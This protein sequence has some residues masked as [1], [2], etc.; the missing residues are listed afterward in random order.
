MY[1]W[2]GVER[3]KMGN[4][5]VERDRLLTETHTKEKQVS[6]KNGVFVKIW[7]IPIIISFVG[8]IVSYVTMGES[9]SQKISQVE[10]Q[11]VED[12]VVNT[13]FYQQQGVIVGIVNAVD[14]LDKT[15]T[16]F[17]EKYDQN[18]EADSKVIR[19]ILKAVKA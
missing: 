17:I 1:E 9:F 15:Q 11:N 3:R 14:R 13:L 6:D 4:D 19:E 5:W 18:R 16:K 12:K 8:A 7:M 2:K 10:I